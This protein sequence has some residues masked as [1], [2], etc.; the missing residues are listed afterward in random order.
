MSTLTITTALDLLANGGY[1]SVAYI[2][3]DATKRKGGEII[4]IAEAKIIN[5]NNLQHVKVKEY[6]ST[7]TLPTKAQNHYSHATRNLVL[8][9]GLHRKMHIY[10]LLHV[11]NIPV[12]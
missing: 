2:T 8:R 12:I 5:Q 9:N 6:T 7:N 1:H 3:A 4:R 11:D 10:L